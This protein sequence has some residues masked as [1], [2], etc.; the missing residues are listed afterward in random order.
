MKIL[1][2]WNFKL[3]AL[4]IEFLKD[5][6]TIKEI[7]RNRT[8]NGVSWLEFCL[9]QVTPIEGTPFPDLDAVLIVPDTLATKLGAISWSR[10]AT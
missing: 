10:I 5:F 8:P 2:R 6:Y 7:C 9:E 3:Y 4:E 1:L